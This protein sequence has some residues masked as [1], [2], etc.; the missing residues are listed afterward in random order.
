MFLKFN[1]LYYLIIFILITFITSFWDVVLYNN[2]FF[3]A[4]VLEACK[5]KLIVD[6]IYIYNDIELVVF[7]DSSVFDPNLNVFDFF[8]QWHLLNNPRK[9]ALLIQ[10]NWLSGE[11]I[12]GFFFYN[13][14]KVFFKLLIT[15]QDTDK[16]HFYNTN[17]VF[18][19]LY[20]L[21]RLEFI[22][23]YP[24]KKWYGELS[25]VTNDVIEATT[26]FDNLS[27]IRKTVL[28]MSTDKKYFEIY[29]IKDDYWTKNYDY[30]LLFEKKDFN[31]NFLKKYYNNIK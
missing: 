16:Y 27:K 9:C 14:K 29:F 17:N 23:Q 30:K 8:S 18:P 4:Y 25:N 20:N 12:N 6:D 26:I 11:M 2:L 21:D 19:L 1:N 22:L 5:A 15:Y 13:D 10:G 7:Y 31:H 28:I 3:D 24:F